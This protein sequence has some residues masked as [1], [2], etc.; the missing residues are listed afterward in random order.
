MN[1]HSRKSYSAVVALLV[2]L[3]VLA[4]S[5]SSGPDRAGPPD[6]IEIA[7]G[8]A[9]TG[10][11]G[12]LLPD[13]VVAKVTDADGRPVS[14]ARVLWEVTAGAGE[15]SPG[16]SHTNSAGL[17]T[18]A[19]RLGGVAGSTQTMRATVVD[20][21]SGVAIDQASVVAFGEVGPP[22]QVLRFTNEQRDVA[23][24]VAS[25]PFRVRVVDAHGNAIPGATVQWTMTAGSGTVS[26]ATT[27]TDEEGYT[28]NVVTPSAQAGF[29]TLT[30]RAGTAS[31]TFSVRIFDMAPMVTTVGGD[32][33]GIALTSAGHVVV[34]NI[35]SSLLQ[36]FTTA[37]P[38]A[39]QE[40]SLIGTP[41]NV[42]VNPAGSHA[43]IANMGSI[44]QGLQI[45]D[46]AT[47][48]VE[49]VAIPNGGHA[50]AWSPDRSRVFVTSS[51]SNVWVVDAASRTIV[52]TVLVTGGPWG[53]AFRTSGA[54]TIVYIS[55]RDAGSVVEANARTGAVL[56]TFDV[57]GRP[58]G[59]AISADGSTLWVANESL[60]E[61]QR[62]ATAS[63]EITSTY[64][65]VQANDVALSPD[66]ATLF[67]SSHGGI[68]AVLD[69]ATFAPLR[70]Y[71]LGG[72]SGRR[73]APRPDNASALLTVSTGK[74]VSITR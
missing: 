38:W 41:V 72:G 10:A 21:L 70:F 18:T 43:W 73:L 36:R 46:L 48:S 54:D 44:V 19:W 8:A 25:E 6:D 60:G 2:A 69:V 63:G 61:V 50:L 35:G 27:V 3:T 15:V 39:I 28:T 26:A 56:R 64:S 29:G 57:G 20:T 24:G 31:T 34:A 7:D 9:Q 4:C 65:L 49:G 62:V 58:H 71:N 23:A 51:T 14:G 74:V 13:P 16:V 11:A 55:R 33:Y 67:A 53:L 59:I 68:A 37:T 42:I 12:E 22:G 32:P 47:Q 30:A 45:V 17:A 40:T 66:G 5:D 1:R 52:D